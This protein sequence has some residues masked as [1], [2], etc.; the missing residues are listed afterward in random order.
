[1][2]K[3][4]YNGK[5]CKHGHGTL[6]YS[7]NRN[8]VDCTNNGARR[9]QKDNPEKLKEVWRR[10][11]LKKK[12]DLTAEQYESML[13]NQNGVCAICEKPPGK[14]RLAVDH[15]H[16]TGAVR[17]LLCSNCNHVLG[18]GLDNPDILRKAAEYLET[19]ST[20]NHHGTTS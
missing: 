14:R 1:M 18:N 7:T 17:A 9:W 2:N 5:E 20:E 13:K 10:S 16:K 3:Q 4:F 6:R 8:C 15:D 11:N 12:F 19:H